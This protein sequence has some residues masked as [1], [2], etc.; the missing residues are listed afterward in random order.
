[1]ID[2]EYKVFRPKT[3]LSSKEVD[4]LFKLDSDFF[5]SPWIHLSWENIHHEDHLLITAKSGDELIG[6]S[7]FLISPADSFAHLLKI[8][9]EPTKRHCGLARKLFE[10]SSDELIKLQCNKLFLEV[11]ETN[12]DAIELYKKMGLKIIHRKKDFY[13]QNRAALIMTNS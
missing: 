1:M 11:E 13:G 6:F 12:T 7:L 4:Q 8:L 10:L 3:E 2:L 9:I 5:P